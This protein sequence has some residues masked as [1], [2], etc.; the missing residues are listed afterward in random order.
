MDQIDVHCR[1]VFTRECISGIGNEETCLRMQVSKQWSVEY[2]K[3]MGRVE[4]IDCACTCSKASDEE[5]GGGR[6]ADYQVEKD[7]T[8]PTAPSP[9]TTHC[10]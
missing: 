5:G 4:M 7:Y 2:N 3:W 1:N 8:F 9:V 6:T 10:I